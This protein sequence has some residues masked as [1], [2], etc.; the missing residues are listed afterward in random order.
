MAV[1]FERLPVES[2]Y[3]DKARRYAVLLDGKEIGVVERRRCQHWKKAGR[4]RVNITASWQWCVR[5]MNHLEF[6]TRK[7]AV[8]ALLEKQT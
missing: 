2:F 5:G 7:A 3:G 6:P 1:T 8:E 4:I